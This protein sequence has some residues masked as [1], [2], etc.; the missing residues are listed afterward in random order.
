[1]VDLLGKISKKWNI[2]VIDLWS[3]EAFNIITEEKRQL[4]MADPIH[5]TQ[6][7]YLEWWTPVMEDALYEEIRR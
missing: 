1:M 3:D 2:S 6:A 4:Y 7:G 5:P